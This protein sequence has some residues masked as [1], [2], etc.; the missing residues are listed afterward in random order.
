MTKISKKQAK[1][2]KLISETERRIFFNSSD[3]NGVL[4]LLHILARQLEEAYKK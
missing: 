3:R 1:I 4:I 2:N